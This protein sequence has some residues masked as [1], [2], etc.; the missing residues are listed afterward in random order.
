MR[1]SKPKS[2]V[3]SR[4][5]TRKSKSPVKSRKAKSKSPVK[6]R[7]PIMKSKSKTRKSKS[8][9]PCKKVGGSEVRTDIQP[10]EIAAKYKDAWVLEPNVKKGV[11]IR[12]SFDNLDFYEP[13]ITEGI[14]SS[15]RLAEENNTNKTKLYPFVF[16]RAPT[17]F[18]GDINYDS[19]EE[20]IKS[21]FDGTDYPGGDP[22]SH[23][24]IR[25]D[26]NN[27][28]V[29]S[30][31]LRASNNPDSVDISRIKLTEYLN[32]MINNKKLLENDRSKGIRG[33]PYFNKVNYTY[34]NIRNEVM[35]I[36]KTQY[37]DII[38]I[39]P[40]RNAEI[41]IETDIVAPKLFA[42][43]EKSIC[44]QRSAREMLGTVPSHQDL[45]ATMGP[46]KST[47]ELMAKL[48]S[49]IRKN[50]VTADDEK[51][52]K[53]LQADKR[54]WLLQSQPFAFFEK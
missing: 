51:L 42:Y 47:E 4:S 15:K 19:I 27:T 20:E 37:H 40:T 28:Y 34:I 24:Y 32:I 11:L 54:R 25:V 17:K 26:P 31:E 41:L 48:S 13:I 8:K 29:Y 14:K 12:H 16:F 5:P 30:S 39:D 38:P 9:N 35:D 2:P 43:K 46:V 36:E 44:K 10:Y 23:I 45:M 3:K 21:L 1:K 33:I 49:S 53:R 7:S 52:K 50:N 22:D 6:S 18:N